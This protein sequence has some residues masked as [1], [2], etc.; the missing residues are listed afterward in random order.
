MP[1]LANPLRGESVLTLFAIFDLIMLVAYIAIAYIV[2]ASVI[3]VLTWMYAW[4]L[5]IVLLVIVMGEDE[6]CYR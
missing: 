1:N 6:R 5:G 4:Q 2:C 3:V